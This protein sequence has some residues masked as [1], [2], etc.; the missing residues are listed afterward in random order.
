MPKY[1]I[2]TVPNAGNSCGEPRLCVY[3]LW[4]SK[5]VQPI[6]KGLSFLEN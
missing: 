3:L 5:M 1:K 4:K 6:W 2:A